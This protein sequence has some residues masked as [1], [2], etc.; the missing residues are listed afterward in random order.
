MRQLLIIN[1]SVASDAERNPDSTKSHNDLEF[2]NVNDISHKL[3]TKDSVAPEFWLRKAKKSSSD[4]FSPKRIAS[5][6]SLPLISI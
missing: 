2:E 4:R 6:N 5:S 1:V 3:S